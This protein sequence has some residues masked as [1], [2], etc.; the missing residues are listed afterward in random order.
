MPCQRARTI[1]RNIVCSRT[2]FSVDIDKY[3]AFYLGVQYTVDENSSQTR[4]DPL[5]HGAS[6]TQFSNQ[7]CVHAQLI[8][9]G[10]TPPHQSLQFCPCAFPC[11]SYIICCPGA[12]YPQGCLPYVIAFLFRFGRP[13]SSC[14]SCLAWVWQLQRGRN[15]APTPD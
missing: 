15:Q 11:K 3:T 8:V 6:A 5:V 1:P 12:C 14:N 7:Q 10:V 13:C 2:C 9:F 4:V